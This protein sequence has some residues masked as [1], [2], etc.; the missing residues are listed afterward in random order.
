[1][2]KIQR[3]TQRIFAGNANSDLISAFGTM[4]TG[5]PVHSTDLDTL[6]NANY[7]QGWQDAILNDKAPYLEELNG[8]Q[9]GFSKQLCYL[10]QE[11]IP[12]WDS[13][14]TYYKTSL[15]K[16]IDDSNKV[17]IYQSLQDNNTGHQ[18]TETSYWQLAELAYGGL[19][20]GTVFA[21]LCTSSFVPE[22]CVPANGEEYSG[23]TFYDLW[24]NFLIP[25]RLQTCT[26]EEYAQTL[27]TYGNCPKF[28][29]D[30]QLK[31][32]K[33]PTIKDGTF[34]QQ[35][36]SDSELG[37][38]YNAGLPNITGG[39][40][41][42]GGAEDLGSIRGAFNG[43]NRGSWSYAHVQNPQQS[44]LNVNFDASYSN[45][46]YGNSTTVQP[47]AIAL[48]YFI[49]LTTGTINASAMNW[50]EYIRNINGKVDKTDKEWAIDALQ[51]VYTAGVSVTS[52]FVCPSD[53]WIYACFNEGQG[54][55]RMAINGQ[56]VLG[57]GALGQQD[58]IYIIVP[59]MVKKND[60]ITGSI[61]SES[62]FYPCKGVN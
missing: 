52:G 17:K 59:T 39:Y 36:N 50:D 11:G 45:S 13:E 7:Q 62:R 18:L 26:Y 49:V 57:V 33:V 19:P 14:T 40:S 25:G 15:V 10:F 21:S 27:S 24:T 53:G 23:E 31:T 8:V 51:P 44:R 43:T 58:H 29:I 34:I 32:F 28:A 22:N 4:K 30:T 41:A 12:E 46:I 20:V 61:N 2:P 54:P 38:S 55:G 1:M 16:F 56:N 47:T 42:N 48:R 37:K 3:E 5:V 9:Y 35:A 60:V 6:Q